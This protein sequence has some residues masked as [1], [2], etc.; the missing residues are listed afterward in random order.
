MVVGDSLSTCL[1]LVVM[2]I[3]LIACIYHDPAYN[4][5]L[6]AY[7]RRKQRIWWAKLT[8]T[9]LHTYGHPIPRHVLDLVWLIPLPMDWMRLKKIKKKFDLLGI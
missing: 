8:F 6:L 3:R 1:V 7:L 9:W 2:G 5:G 4:L